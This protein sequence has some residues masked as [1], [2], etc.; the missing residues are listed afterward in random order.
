MESVLLGDDA[1][2]PIKDLPKTLVARAYRLDGGDYLLIVNRTFENVVATLDLPKGVCTSLE[3]RCGEGVYLD[4]DQLK[5]IF[6]GLG[7]A[8]LKWGR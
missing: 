5:V 1:A 8:F 7:Y 2:L 6:D 4:G 3:T